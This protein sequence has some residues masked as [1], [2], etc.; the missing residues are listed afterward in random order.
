MKTR[1]TKHG[2][3]KRKADLTK[4]T[5]EDRKN[6]PEENL[7]MITINTKYEQKHNLSKIPLHTTQH[8][9][10]PSQTKNITHTAG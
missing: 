8:F 5:Q 2:R 6:N 3:S 4:G 7:K 1:L 10:K 9:N